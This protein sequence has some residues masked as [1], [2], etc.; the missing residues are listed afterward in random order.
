[1]LANLSRSRRSL[2]QKPPLNPPGIPSS[3]LGTCGLLQLLRL[4][5][6]PLSCCPPPSFSFEPSFPDFANANVFFR[7]QA[8]HLARHSCFIP[9]AHTTSILKPSNPAQLSLLTYNIQAR[10]GAALCTFQ[11]LRCVDPMF[12]NPRT[13][14]GA[15]VALGEIQAAL[16]DSLLEQEELYWLA[17]N[18][19]E[20]RF[21]LFSCAL[22]VSFC[23]VPF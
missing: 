23:S 8:F 7:L 22:P 9:V 16:G 13:L 14:K 19:T 11:E 17:L 5:P 3:P 1:M 20:C 12:Q 15:L 4:L 21:L 2:T 10:Y 6:L 18:G